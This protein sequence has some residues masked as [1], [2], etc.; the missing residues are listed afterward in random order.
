MAY[1]ILLAP[2]AKKEFGKLEQTA[3]RR[4]DEVFD[5]IAYDPYVGKKLG[6]E[7]K[8]LWAVRAWPYRIMYEIFEARLIV[9]VIRIRHR[10]DIYR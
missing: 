10:K 7:Y 4:V 6:G 2:S 9:H 5:L 8:G 1:Q 3:Q